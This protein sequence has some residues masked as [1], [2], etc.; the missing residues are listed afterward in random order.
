MVNRFELTPEEKELSKLRDLVRALRDND[1][2]ACDCGEC[3]VCQ[4][5]AAVPREQQPPIPIAT[6]PC[7]RCGE[8]DRQCWWCSG[9]MNQQEIARG[10]PRPS[11]YANGDRVRVAAWAQ[12]NGTI[13]GWREDMGE[14]W[15]QLDDQKK[16]PNWHAFSAVYL[17]RL[18]RSTTFIAR[19]D[20]SP[21]HEV[22]PAP[23]GSRT[24]TRLLDAQCCACDAEDVAVLRLK[25]RE[26]NVVYQLC[27]PCVAALGERHGD[28]FCFHAS[29]GLRCT[30]YRE[31][32]L[33]ERKAV[34]AWLR[35]QASETRLL[36]NNLRNGVND[37]QLDLTAEHIEKEKHVKPELR[38]QS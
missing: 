16:Y 29:K 25:A 24:V 6:A 33:E 30:R 26:S 31:G 17:T 15:V 9:Q 22:A 37:R 7:P 19:R 18:V 20:D 21:E 3:V 27:E 8:C 5:Y 38:V 11:T 2:D 1:E 23:A 4:L 36:P 28:G 32:A 10:T 13:V 34:V 35:H 14:W 12:Q